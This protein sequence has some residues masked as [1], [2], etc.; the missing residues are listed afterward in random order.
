MN[1]IRNTKRIE[2]IFKKKNKFGENTLPDNKIS[3]VIILIETLWYQQKVKRKR[4]VVTEK[5][6]QN[7]THSLALPQICQCNARGEGE[8]MFISITDARTTGIVRIIK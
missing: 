7:Y 1:D 4:S 6:F 2:E 5:R 3:C 8:R